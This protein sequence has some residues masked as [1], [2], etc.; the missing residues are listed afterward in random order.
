MLCASAWVAVT[1]GVAEQ[2]ANAAA[3]SSATFLVFQ[4]GIVAFL[5]PAT[6]FT[7]PSCFVIA[8]LCNGIM[9]GFEAMIQPAAVGRVASNRVGHRRPD[10]AHDGN[11]IAHGPQLSFGR[12]R[13]R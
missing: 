11:P 6:P 2:P 8:Q 4:W 5:P 9:K 12:R 10:R 1:I 3:A 13:T 7:A